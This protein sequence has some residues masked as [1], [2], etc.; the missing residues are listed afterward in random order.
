MIGSE[1]IELHDLKTNARINIR[2]RDI[3]CVEESI[4]CVM[5]EIGEVLDSRLRG[6]NVYHTGYVSNVRECYDEIIR[7][8]K[9]AEM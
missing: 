7:M 3:S 9:E 6:C 4:L 2:E 5:S 1:F 8:I